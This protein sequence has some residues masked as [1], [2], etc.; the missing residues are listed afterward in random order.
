MA[1][2]KKDSSLRFEASARLQRLF[3]RELIP[4]DDSA[5]EELTKNAYDSNA[6]E[7]TITIVRPS[8]D[9]D[10]EIEIRDNGLGLS[11]TEF[12]RVWM[13]AGYSEKAGQPLPGTGRVQ[14]GEKGIGRFAADKLGRHLIVL[15]K[16]RG[17][18]EALKV[19][20]D[21]RK[22]EKKK[23]LL[24]DISNP[25]E[26]VD[27]PL[28]P[29]GSS[30]TI[31]R[32]RGL[33]SDWPDKAIEEMRRRLSRL[34]NPYDKGQT[35]RIVLNAPSRK[36]SGPIVG[37][38]IKNADF[39][40]EV[41]RSAQGT[42][43]MKRRNRVQ[44]GIPEWSDW[45]S[46][47]IT[48]KGSV[49]EQQDFGP[50]NA[51][52]FFFVDRPKKANIGDAIPGVAIYRDGMR[53]EPAGSS[54]ADWL[55]LLEKRAKRAGHMPLVPS[56]LFGFVKIS[57]D[58]NP[59]LQD[60]TN[61]RAFVHGPQLDTFRQFLKDRLSELEAQVESEVAKPRWEKSKQL[62]SQKL[63]QARYNTVS[64]MSLSLAHELRQP[65][66]AIQTA[67]ENIRDYLKQKGITI[68]EV[69][70]GTD[71]IRRNVARIEKHIQFLKSLG[72]GRQEQ[73]S[74]DA[75]KAAE[76][77][78]GVFGGVAAAQNVQLVREGS[79]KSMV[80]SNHATFLATLTNLVLNALQAIEGQDEQKPHHIQ[81]K[82]EAGRKLTK[83]RVE[84]DGPGI[85]EANRTRL[86]KRLTT[87]KQGGMGI[88]LI[89]WR[90]AL[91]MFSGE[92][93]C[94]SFSDPTTFVITV[95]TGV[96]DGSSSSG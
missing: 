27:E 79:P 25:Y 46:V 16:P 74:F 84:D 54:S 33:R 57:R 50:V 56:R 49:P 12:N 23:L 70:S 22:F 61:R 87:S 26:H 76:E 67:S 94:E 53:V 4:D 83:I 41:T 21:W 71:V 51:R 40:W 13:R 91:Q 15:T 58:E 59:E 65:L 6:S 38:E 48:K 78:I 90:E 63:L 10:G 14:V 34:L 80:L 45:E 85:P 43:R 52:F 2:S 29:K 44:R 20:F 72:S 88:G 77:V 42:I 60:A 1:L 3:G 82:F 86:F 28:L 9:R 75:V 36:L 18:R 68:A 95:P 35:F 24:S 7:V 92:L 55:G 64:I 66:Q 73:E 17:A 47:L 81:I 8:G 19:T 30:G 89:V 62:K 69:D 5:V 32:I 96:P 93:E 31:L 37:S 11:L 39:E